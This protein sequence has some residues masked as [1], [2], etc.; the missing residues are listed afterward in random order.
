MKKVLLIIGVI[1]LFIGMTS[2][3]SGATVSTLVS[4]E[5]GP[6]WQYI[7][8][9]RIRS[10]EIIEEDG[11]KYILGFALHI[12]GFVWNVFEKYPK[13]PFPTRWSYHK[14]CIPYEGTEIIGPTPLG[15]YFLIA[16]GTL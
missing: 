16:K 7:L 11:E 5:N 15:N 8:F 14:F 1:T 6:G 13:L 12:R 10:Y 2:I 4:Q 3:T 9:G